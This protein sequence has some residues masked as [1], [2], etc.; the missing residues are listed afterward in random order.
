M[1]GIERN[2]RF[3]QLTAAVCWIVAIAIVLWFNVPTS[4][5]VVV[6]RLEV[7]VLLLPWLVGMFA[8]A[9]LLYARWSRG[10]ISRLRTSATAVYVAALVVVFSVAHGHF[11]FQLF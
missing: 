5:V 9:P 6:T 10:V 1:V 7:G 11:V 3:F 8:L 4:R 2:L